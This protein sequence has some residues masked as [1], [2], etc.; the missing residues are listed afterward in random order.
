MYGFNFRHNREELLKYILF[1]AAGVAVAALIIVL[2]VNFFK[3]MNFANPRC[4]YLLI[5]VILGIGAGAAFKQFFPATVKYPFTQDFDFK[6][7]YLGALVK[8]VPFTLCSLALI[9]CVFALARPRRSGKAILPPAKGIDIMMTVDTSG[10]METN[11]FTPTRMAA[12]K[13]TAQNF[14]DKRE[15]DRIGIVVFAQVAM[16]QCPLTLDYNALHSYVDS[17][18]VNM[19]GGSG[20]TAI[21]DAIAVSAQHLKDSKTKSKIIILITDGESNSGTIDPIAAAKAA[22]S[23]GIKV[24]TVAI[25][26][27][28]DNQMPVEGLFGTT[29]VNVANDADSGEALLRVVAKTTGGEFFRARSNSELEGI[30]SKIDSLEKTEFQQKT[31]VNYKDNYMGLLNTA[32]ILLLLA[33]LC[34]K[35]IFIKIP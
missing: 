21:G 34:D 31:E 3:S 8:W 2:I 10:S 9:L 29:Y 7:G 23:Y 1:A 19:L 17:V 6:S 14:I 11:D 33:F 15:S 25:A 30:Y 16:L 27:N 32:V 12:A 28:G 5:P 20:G 13:N 4:L 26:G 35:I 22:A 24:Y 18:D